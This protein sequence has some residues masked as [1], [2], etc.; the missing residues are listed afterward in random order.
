MMHPRV[1]HATIDNDH[2]RIPQVER[3]VEGRKRLHKKPA[4]VIEI[5]EIARCQIVVGFNVR[6]VV[7]ACSGIIIGSPYR[8]IFVII[9]VIT[10][11]RGTIVGWSTTAETERHDKYR[12]NDH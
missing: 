3:G 9:V 6:E 10:I 5:D 1:V 4:P 7:V 12:E 11:P 2:K 8:I